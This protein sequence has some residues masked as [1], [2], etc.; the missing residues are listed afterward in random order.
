MANNN[1]TINMIV[2]LCDP[3]RVQNI[4]LTCRCGLRWIE[5][6][7]QELHDS[8]MTAQFECEKCHTLYRLHHHKLQRVEEDVLRDPEQQEFTRISTQDKSQYDS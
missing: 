5:H 7:P 3:R 4:A 6:I 8:D 2:V 1:K